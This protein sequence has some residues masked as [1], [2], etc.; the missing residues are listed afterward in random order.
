[1]IA[2]TIAIRLRSIRG[3]VLF[4]TTSQLAVAERT[5][6]G[7]IG[8]LVRYLGS[9]ILVLDAFWMDHDGKASQIFDQF[10]LVPTP[11]FSLAPPLQSS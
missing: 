10:F 3:H 2:T 11:H 7:Q 6:I 1:M 4:L 8:R 5:S 9:Y